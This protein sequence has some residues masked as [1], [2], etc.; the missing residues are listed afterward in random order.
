M[1]KLLAPYIAIL[2]F[3][4]GLNSAWATILAYHVQIV[5]WS[6]HRMP[7]LVRGWNGRLFVTTVLPCLLAGPIAYL[8]LPCMTQPSGLPEWLAAHGLTGM[9]M[10]LMIPYFGIVHPLLEQAHWSDL[11][12]RGWIAHLAFAGYHAIVLVSLLTTPW[13]ILCLG[14]L[15]AASAIW[16]LVGSRVHLGLLIPACGHICADSGIVVAAWLRMG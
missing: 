6:W 12:S 10:T 4:L 2:I 9:R 7:A 13:L 8:L 3:W 14:V 5:F 11:R 15:M 16:T 1:L